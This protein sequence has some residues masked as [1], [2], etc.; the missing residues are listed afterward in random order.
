MFLLQIFANF[1]LFVIGIFG[2][3]INRLNLLIVLMCIELILLSVNL[4]FIFFS[5]YLDDM[6]GQ[7]ISLLILTVASAESTIG[8]A[9]LIIYYR[10]HQH[11]LINNVVVLRG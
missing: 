9:I 6:Y 10:L 11:I 3:L 4:N 1:I 7:I 8:L 5:L 2:V